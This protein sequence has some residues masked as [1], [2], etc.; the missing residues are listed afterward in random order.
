MYVCG[1]MDIYVN[2]RSRIKPLKVNNIGFK[3]PKV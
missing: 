2:S 1:P 3:V